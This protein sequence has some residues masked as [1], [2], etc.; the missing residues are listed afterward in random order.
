M[1]TLSILFTKKQHKINFKSILF[2]LVRNTKLLS[3]VY[4][5]V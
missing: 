1:V 4:V 5:S 2:T 3:F